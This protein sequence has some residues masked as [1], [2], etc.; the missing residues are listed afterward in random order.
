MTAGLF[1]EVLFLGAM[2]LMIFSDRQLH[3]EAAQVLHSFT[4]F[5]Q[6][7]LLARFYHGGEFRVLQ[8]EKQQAGYT[9]R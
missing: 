4:A 2:R 1:S 9:L 8:S 5:L 6:R 7:V 3:G